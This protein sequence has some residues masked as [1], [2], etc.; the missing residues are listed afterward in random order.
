MKKDRTKDIF[1][2]QLRKLP[3]IQVGC[4]KAGIAR[5]TAYQWMSEYPEFKK[6]VEA[7]LEDGE[8]FMNEMSESQLISLIKEKNFPA[9]SLWLRNRHPKFRPKLDI[10]A[11]FQSPQEELT[12]EQEEAVR[13]ALELASFNVEPENKEP[14]KANE[15]SK[16][17]KDPADEES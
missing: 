2:E 7:A 11:T 17:D 10:T 6:A 3:I 1:L 5:S 9:I 14:E 4:E 13:R 8:K 12:P 15:E 16:E